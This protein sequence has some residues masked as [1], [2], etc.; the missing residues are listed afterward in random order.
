MKWGRR[1]DTEDFGSY[2]TNALIQ[3]M[4]G[5]Y[6]TGLAAEH[7]PATDEMLRG[8]IGQGVKW[9][10][11]WASAAE[12]YP[13]F[14]GL[15]AAM[16]NFDA[17]YAYASGRT[18]VLQF[19]TSPYWFEDAGESQGVAP[20]SVLA[21]LGVPHRVKIAQSKLAEDFILD[22]MAGGSD[23]PGDADG[24]VRTRAFMNLVSRGRR[25][26]KSPGG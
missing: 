8:Y 15:G 25:S 14:G 23:S 5:V 6:R 21:F 9:E 13:P 20:R 4:T 24:Q 2:A 22:L 12:A 1:Q 19:G 26:L 16:L 11:V 18:T 17:A 10:L 7:L 3:S